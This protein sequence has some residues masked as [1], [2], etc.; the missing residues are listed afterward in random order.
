MIVVS[1]TSPIINLAAVGRLDLLRQLYKKIVIPQAV[2]DEITSSSQEKPG[3]KEV[4]NSPW[5]EKS[6]AKDQRLVNALIVEIDQGEAEAIVLA[7]EMKA[8]LLLIDE[9]IGRNVASRFDV[10]F[11]GLLGVLIHAKR[12]GLVQNVRPILQDLASKAGF[13]MSRELHAKVL[14]AAG[15]DTGRT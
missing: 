9:R 3:A 10:R 7:L 11:I 4:R 2:Y 6:K 13:W 5:I 12:R 14:Q 8:D 1:N 15:E